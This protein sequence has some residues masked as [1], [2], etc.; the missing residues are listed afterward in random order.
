VKNTSTVAT[1]TLSAALF[2]VAGA[3]SYFT[4][5]VTR[6]HRDIP[7]ILTQVD[8][9][10]GKVDPILD[11]VKEIRKLVPPIVAEIAA[12]RGEIPSIVKEIEETRKLIPPILQ[13]VRG[14][15]DAIPGIL[16]TVDSTVVSIAQTNKEIAATRQLVPGVLEE[17]KAVR[18]EIEA[19]RKSLPTTLDRLDNLVAKA[20]IA[21]QKAT[22]GAVTGVFTG[23][24][25]A[26]FRALVGLGNVA[27]GGEFTLAGEDLT[28]ATTTAISLTELDKGA[29]KTWANPESGYRGK[30]TLLDKYKDDGQDCVTM[31][32]QAWKGDREVID[33][34]FDACRQDPGSPWE[35]KK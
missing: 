24:I 4:F 17:V 3:I 33:R 13:E 30:L 14:S 11:E 34:V 23:V 27:A 20:S 32:H 9:T 35:L 7:A 31:K 25:T 6:I 2:S 22:E 12:V 19:T 15:R 8:S 28:I 16:K 5:E 26:P 18:K 10:S 29:K 21:G 1:Y